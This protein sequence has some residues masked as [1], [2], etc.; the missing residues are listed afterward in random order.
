MWGRVSHKFIEEK[1]FRAEGGWKRPHRR[2]GM[3]G[4]VQRIRELV[5][6]LLRK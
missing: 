6:V 3:G 1:L 4:R 2:T 5:K